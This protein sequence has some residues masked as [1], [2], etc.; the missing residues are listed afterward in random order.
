MKILATIVLGAALG[1]LGAGAAPRGTVNETLFGTLSP[2]LPTYDRIF[3]SQVDPDCGAASTDS[4]IG[5]DV[6]FEVFFLMVDSVE[7]LEVAYDGP[8]TSLDDPV[9]SLYC[10]PFD[11]AM[12]AANLIAYNDD[13]AG[14]RLSAFDAGNMVQMSPGRGY[15]LVASTYDPADSGSFQLNITSPTAHAAAPLAG[16]APQPAHDATDVAVDSEL[17]WTHG[18]GASS[19][20]VYFGTNPTPGMAEF[21]GN[22]ITTSFAP[23]NLDI[24]TTYY[25]RVDEINGTGTTTGAIWSFSTSAIP[26]ELQRFS[27]D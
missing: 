14:S 19:H 27:I 17:H 11:P 25:W 9:L 3:T 8:G 15:W 16:S 22:Q 10:D 20:D 2:A 1:C 4:T 5:N 12:P 21:Q 23:G 26:V 18:L 7:N 24:S 6:S 13:I